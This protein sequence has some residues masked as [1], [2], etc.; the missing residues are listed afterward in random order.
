[1]STQEGQQTLEDD[2]VATAAAGIKTS[3]TLQVEGKTV[4]VRD[5][6]KWKQCPGGSEAEDFHRTIC[7]AY[8]AKNKGHVPLPCK[9]LA[10]V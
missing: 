7:E 4:C 5:G 3:C 2:F 8:A 1:M 9:K 6:G 10:V